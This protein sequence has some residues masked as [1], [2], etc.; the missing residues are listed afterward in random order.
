[1]LRLAKVRGEIEMKMQNQDL[2]IDEKLQLMKKMMFDQDQKMKTKADKTL[3]NK[4]ETD[5]KEMRINFEQ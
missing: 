5:N 2:A 1:M 3:F 4:M